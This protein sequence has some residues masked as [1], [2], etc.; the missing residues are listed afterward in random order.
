MTDVFSSA[1]DNDIR[2]RDGLTAGREQA[3]A[4][5]YDAHAP[6]VYGLALRITGDQGCAEDIT[7]QVFVELWRQPE[8]FDPKRSRLRGWLCMIARR[9]AIDWLR[10]RQTQDQ[11]RHHVAESELIAPYVEDEVLTSLALKQVRQAVSDLPHIHQQ[12]ILLAYYQGLT[13]REVGRA[14]GIPEGTAKY[15]LRTALRRIGDQLAAQGFDR[16]YT[17]N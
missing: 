7:Q 16:S 9:R 3:L 1:D 12:V 14:L 8:R 11:Y 13:Y 10:R 6:A 17:L 5:A 15:R 4:E 2:I